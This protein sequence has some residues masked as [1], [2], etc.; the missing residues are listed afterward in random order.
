MGAFAGKPASSAA[1]RPAAAAAVEAR[2]AIALAAASSRYDVLLAALNE[3]DALEPVFSEARSYTKELEDWIARYASLN[4]RLS[5]AG[6]AIA[7]NIPAAAT[8]SESVPGGGRPGRP[9]PHAEYVR[10]TPEEPGGVSSCEGRLTMVRLPGDEQREALPRTSRL[11]GLRLTERT[12]LPRMRT[13]VVV[14]M[15]T[16]GLIGTCW[17]TFWRAMMTRERPA[18]AAG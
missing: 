13:L 14:L 10:T 17:L 12:Q 11:S 1:T 7:R 5:Q 8:D 18:W 6:V 9:R 4:E 15:T 2:R 3:H 16:P